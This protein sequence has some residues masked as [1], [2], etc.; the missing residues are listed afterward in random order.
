MYALRKGIHYLYNDVAEA[1][2][3]LCPAL[4]LGAN[5]TYLLG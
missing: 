2:S 4:D 5:V 1:I 3:N